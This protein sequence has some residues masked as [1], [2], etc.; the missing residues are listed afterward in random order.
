MVLPEGVK[1]VWDVDKAYREMTTT[2][3]RICINGLWRWQPAD[4]AAEAV[5]T[6]GWGYFRVPDS[7]PGG[8]GGRGGPG[9][10]AFYPNPNW[11]QDA[12]R[13][14]TAAWQQRE[15]TIPQ[16]WAGRRI[17]LHAEYI[18]SFAAV[19]VDG[20]KV[21]EMR[22]P[23]GD[24]DLTSACRPGGKHML[25][26]LVVAMPLRAV[27]LS[28]TDTDRAREVPGNVG[29]K[30]ILGDIYLAS[31]PQGPRV[32]DVKVETSVRNWQI[33]FETALDGLDPPTQY[34]LRARI[35]DAGKPVAD[36]TCK[37]FKGSELSNGRMAMTEHWKPEKLWDTITPQNQYDVSVSLLDAKGEALDE[38]Q[39]VRFGF[40]E[41]WID[42][43]DFY[44]NGT[45]IYLSVI[46]LNN[47]IGDSTGASYY[48]TKATIQRYKSFGINFVYT[49]NY[50]CE[51]GRHNN[52]QEV[53]KAAD[54]E[55]MLVSFSQP[56]FS[57]YD[58]E[59]PD[60]DVKNGYAKH[61]AFYVHVAQNHPSVV[62]YST[63]HNATGYSEG[64]N[65]D[66]I[67]GI[68]NPR[69]PWSLR[70]A[71]RAL[72]AEAIIRKLD[73][74]RFVYHHSSGN[75][76]SMNT[77][78]FYANWAPIQEMSDWF[79]HWATFGV[80]PI[81]TCEFSVP[82]LWDYAM[83]RGWYKGKREYG[84]A[85]VPWEY[86]V[87]EWDA[88]FLGD[89][90]YNINE[91]EKNNL[92]WEADQFRAGKVWQRFA[93]PYN[94]NTHVFPDRFTVVAMYV[95]DNWR[96]FRTW[97]MSANS[98]LWDH[99]SYWVRAEGRQE[100]Q[101]LAIAWDN[102]QRP[103]PRP[104]YVDEEAAKAQLAFDPSAST[105]TAAAVALYRNNM[106]L[107]AYIGGKAAAFTSKDHNFLPGETAEKQ[108]IVINNSRLPVTCD[109]QW[110]FGLPQPIAGNKTVT[111]PTGQQER[112]PLSFELP[113]G[114][115]PGRYELKAAVKFS[116][117][118]TQQDSFSIDVLPA[119]TAVETKAKIALYDPK[120]DTGKLLTA[121]GVASQPVDAS[122]DL[123]AY[124][125]LIVGKGALTLDGPA[126]DISRVRQGLKVVVFEQTGE[127]LEKRFGF[128]T[129]E[130]G[131]RWVFKRVPDHPL[132]AGIADENL[133]NWRGSATVLP[134]RLTYER[135]PKFN[136]SPT[137]KWCDIVVT[138]LWRC[139]NRGNVASALIEK[140][141][142]G[143]FLPILDGGYALQYT[144]LIEYRE[145]KGMVLFCQTDVSG[146]TESDPAAEALTRN[147]VSYVS[148]WKPAASRVV[149]YVGDPN[150][151]AHL[152]STGLS[153]A[154]YAGGPVPTDRLLVVGPDGGQPLAANAAAVA[155]FL[156]TGGNLLAIGLDEQAANAFLPLK[157]GMT[158]AEHIAAYFE[159]FKAGSLLAGV[160][161]AEVHNRDPRE[162][163]LVSAGATVIGD[164][165]LATVK[166]A[167]VVFCQLVP[168]QFD[169]RGEKM[170]IKRTFRRVSCLL[171]RLLANMGASG[172]TQL[173]EHFQ[174]PVAQTEKRWLDGLYLDVPEEWDDPYR[175]FCW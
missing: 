173:L 67:D 158:K 6:D 127:I 51:P 160:S 152:E 93:Y 168:W 80:K 139:G 39:P 57:A 150:G 145:G 62:C 134:Q 49:H 108:L 35:T 54:D 56:H 154:T 2:R 17:T 94:L 96:A 130:Y 74:S 33:T 141:A 138:R 164:G 135:T 87:A 71:G 148:G 43:R 115:A 170:N 21:G 92:R 30:G 36:F 69:D 53:L 125:T 27:M 90:S 110:S 24:V 120:G 81:L 50:G 171:T 128:R 175:F 29:R 100:P 37:P 41:F 137:V 133:R 162:L 79:E 38:A 131:L 136:Y 155:D 113:K 26:M 122:A 116:N 91:E 111:L 98:P 52:F 85:P 84:S 47:G 121:M 3:E 119:P 165:V 166:D 161:P 109:C 172:S 63:S 83:Y 40:R 174:K 70:N 169:Y 46:P 78:N 123:S 167:N 153:V 146:R 95:T 22:Y 144:S 23:W 13:T 8:G 101:P 34:V 117:G 44:L 97:G 77:N 18:N 59:A 73:P 124:D 149:V 42:G 112:V 106:P 88:Q 151:K 20:Q 28:Y 86:C 142:C 157:V 107:L 126:P 68:Q 156:K 31:D 11:G 104:A 163:P 129:A 143:D 19:Y 45:R 64:M 114:L 12:L 140:P 76:G 72:R 48:A 14:L 159:P 99:Q 60:A 25:S 89:R 7:W 147:I 66:M 132:L 4:K 16:E 61:A 58:W 10:Q 65:P 5:P 82:I 75:L 103:G 55:G 105:P 102:L 15:I 32:S 1:A 118:E 9:A